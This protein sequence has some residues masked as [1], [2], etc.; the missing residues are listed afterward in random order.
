MNKEIKKIGSKSPYFDKNKNRLCLGDDVKFCGM[1]GYQI[2]IRDE[3]WVV[4]PIGSLCYYCIRENNY[5]DK[6]GVIKK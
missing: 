3:E 4:Y 1:S 2:R 5:A 6:N